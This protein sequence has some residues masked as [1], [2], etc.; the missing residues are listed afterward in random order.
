MSKILIVEDDKFLLEMVSKAGIK[1]GFDIEFA[2]DGEEGL[3]KIETEKFDLVLLDLIL[4]KL[5]GLELLKKLRDEN[6]NIPVI[7]LSNL[8]DQESIDSA[9][10]L[11]VKDYIVKAHSTPSEIINKVKTF[12][13]EKDKETI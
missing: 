9:K 12:L 8:Y 10:S 7:V 2:V 4:P 11:G 5:H 13:L 6:N 1:E 3:L